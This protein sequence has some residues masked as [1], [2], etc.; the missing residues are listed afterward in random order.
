MDHCTGGP[1]TDGFDFLTPL[2]NWVEN[3]AQPAGVACVGHGF[4]AATYQ[5]VGNYI[6]G[7]FINAPT[8]RSRMLCPYPQQARFTGAISLVNGV[9]VAKQSFGSR[10]R[11]E[12]YLYQFLQVATHDFNGDGKSDILWRDTS[13]NIGMW[14]MNGTT[15]SQSQ[16]LGNVAAWAAVGQRDLPYR[17]HNSEHGDAD[18]LVA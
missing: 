5:V 12:L 2:V 14:L 13:N 7:S 16:V 6:T 11:V 17:F 3:S 8:T 4:N 1:T 9:P 18:V 10:Q 15:I